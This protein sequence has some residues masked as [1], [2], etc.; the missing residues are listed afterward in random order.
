MLIIK[1]LIQT[2][3]I[4]KNAV[5]LLQGKLLIDL[6]YIINNQTVVSAT[7]FT[8]VADYE[9]SIYITKLKRTANET[10]SIQTDADVSIQTKYNT[11]I[12]IPIGSEIITGTIKVGK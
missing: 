9:V 5:A 10:A 8:N 7:S 2:K 3:D 12:T 1:K 4:S 6:G 11:S